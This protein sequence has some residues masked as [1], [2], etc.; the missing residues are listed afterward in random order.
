MSHPTNTYFQKII[1]PML[2]STYYEDQNNENFKKADKITSIAK[3]I[4]FFVTPLLFAL[5]GYS[6][7]F[8]IVAFT[9]TSLLGHTSIFLGIASNIINRE[10]F[11][12]SR[13]VQNIFSNK[14]KYFINPLD[15]QFDLICND[16]T[17][18]MNKLS[19]SSWITPKVFLNNYFSK[20][21]K[22]KSI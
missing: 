7:Y 9:S 4:K 16:Q 11:V 2:K 1:S 14:S 15:N 5:S 18:F 12:M 13:N 19:E 8:G 17:I 6:I 10:V 21:V 20:T 3:R 22:E